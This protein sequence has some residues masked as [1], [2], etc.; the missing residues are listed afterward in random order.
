MGNV[1]FQ[2]RQRRVM[3]PVNKITSREWNRRLNCFNMSFGHLPFRIPSFYVYV[4]NFGAFGKVVISKTRKFSAIV[5]HEFSL[6]HSFV[7]LN[8]TRFVR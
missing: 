6:L 4:A 7:I 1:P 8:V 5:T 2:L 3:F